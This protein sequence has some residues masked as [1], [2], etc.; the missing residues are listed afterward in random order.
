MTTPTAPAA[1]PA[2]THAAHGIR[3][4]HLVA[5]LVS[6]ISLLVQLVLIVRGVNVLVDDDTGL[7][8]AGVATRVLRFFS[9]FTVQSNVIVIATELLLAANPRRTG[10]WFD[11]ARLAG[12]VGITVTFVVYLVALRPI[13]DL[14]GLAAVTDA[15]FHIVVPVMAV[16]G[17]VAFGPRAGF[18]RRTLLTS[19]VWPAAY[20]VYSLVHGALTGWYPYPFVDVT[21]LGY[22]AAM[23]N[24]AVV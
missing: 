3:L 4:W 24:L 7:P 21:Q 20:F 16:V 11:V 19:L 14:S 22:P 2:A 23:R 5:G 9:Y 8:A 17:W 15:G 12:L 6:L 18:V 10:R 13:L 1:P